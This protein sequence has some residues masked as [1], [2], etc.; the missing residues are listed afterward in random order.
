MVSKKM[1]KEFILKICITG[2]TDLRHEFIR[3]FTECLTLPPA[4]AVGIIMTKL[5]QVKGKNIK[6]YLAIEE[7]VVERLRR[8]YYHGASA[9]IITFDKKNQDSFKA[10]R[11]WY[12]QLNEFIP[13]VPIILVGFINKSEIVTLKEGQNLAEEF[14]ASYYETKPTDSK[15]ITKIFHNVT[16][17]ALDYIFT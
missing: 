1:S 9:A 5:I 10:V 8:S 16:E 3:T 15:T 7:E 4:V 6:L 14:G 17:S 13:E 12:N 2:S 11:K